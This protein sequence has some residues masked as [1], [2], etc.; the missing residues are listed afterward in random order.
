MAERRLELSKNVRGELQAMDMLAVII[1]ELFVLALRYHP[2][3]V[4]PDED[5]FVKYSNLAASY[6]RDLL[7]YQSPRFSP[8]PQP[9]LPQDNRSSAELRAE[10][11]EK[12]A[13]LGIIPPPESI[14]V[15]GT[16]AQEVHAS[17]VHRR[18]RP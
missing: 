10:I 13:E 1:R 15:G 2:A 11:M 6:A 16:E 17:P 9:P 4:E 8:I 18:D 7:P 14:T 3:G 5:K 12:L